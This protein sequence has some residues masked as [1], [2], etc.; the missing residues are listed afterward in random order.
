M[1]SASL[2]SLSAS[3]VNKAQVSIAKLAFSLEALRYEGSNDIS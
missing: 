1:A 3:A 2:L